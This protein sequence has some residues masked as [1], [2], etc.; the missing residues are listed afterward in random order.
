MIMGIQKKHWFALILLL[1][2]ISHVVLLRVPNPL[3]ENGAVVREWPLLADLL[4]TFPLLY[5]LL[6]R[7]PL[8]RFLLRSAALVGAGLLFG[9]F[10]IPEQS[11]VI[12]HTLENGRMAMA[13]IIGA[14]ELGVLVFVVRRISALLRVSGNVDQT[15]EQVITERMG[16]GATARLM[17]FEARIWYYGVLMRKGQQLRF[18]G[19]QHFGYANNQGNASNQLGWILVLL[20]EMPLSHLLLHFMASPTIAW[21]ASALTAWS[22][23]YLIAEYRATHWRPVSLAGDAILVRCGVLGSDLTLP[24]AMVEGIKRCDDQQRR[25]PDVRRYRQS[26]SLNLEITLR[27]GSKLPGFLGSLKP[28]KRIYLSLDKPDDFIAACSQQCWVTPSRLTQPTIHE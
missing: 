26:G 23:L 25:A 24:Y 11:K 2:A 12:W 14:V 6:L 8:K 16:A 22:M 17:L 10:A 5:W 28:V 19:E 20:F 4:I 27:A 7:P 21:I 1:S 18:A 13:L 3:N 9:S 15:L